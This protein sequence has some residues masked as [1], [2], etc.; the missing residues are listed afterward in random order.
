MGDSG[1]CTDLDRLVPGGEGSSDGRAGNLV[2]RG[3]LVVL[4]QTSNRTDLRLGETSKTDS[5]AQ[6]NI[7]DI[8][9]WSARH[10]ARAG[11]EG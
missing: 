11:C 3:E 9:T 1:R 10:I 8:M 5:T 6:R 7:A 4:A 2:E